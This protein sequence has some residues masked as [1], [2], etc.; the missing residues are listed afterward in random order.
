M[1]HV[2]S[3]QNN[4]ISQFQVKSY[5]VSDAVFVDTVRYKYEIGLS[6]ANCW[7]CCLQGEAPIIQIGWGALAASF[8]LSLAMTVWGR[9]GL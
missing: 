9:S 6:N 1:A 5:V 8:S 4:T 2:I 7:V 3:Q